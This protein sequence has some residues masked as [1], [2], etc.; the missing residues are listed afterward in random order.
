MVSV[1]VIAL[2]YPKAAINKVIVIRII[3]IF[4]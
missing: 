3:V 4:I 2:N 1:A